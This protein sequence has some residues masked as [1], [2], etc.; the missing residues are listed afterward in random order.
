MINTP[1]LMVL[2]FLVLK[3]FCFLSATSF[4]RVINQIIISHSEHYKVSQKKYK[5]FILYFYVYFTIFSTYI[6]RFPFFITV[7]SQKIP[8]CSIKRRN[9]FWISLMSQRR[10]SSKL[11]HDSF[12]IMTGY[13]FFET[14]SRF[15]QNHDVF[16]RLTRLKIGG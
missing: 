16:R 10:V 8:N 2:I 12:R 5:A 11:C 6:L 15:F 9:P 14:L 3:T 13:G 1:T 4:L 7:I